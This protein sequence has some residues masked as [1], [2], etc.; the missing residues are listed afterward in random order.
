MTTLPVLP[1]GKLPMELL[2]R[3]LGRYDSLDDRV[4]VGPGVG[5]DAAVLDF[6]DVNLVVKSDPI[7]FPSDDSALYLVSVNANDL[8]CL[9]AVPRW[10][11]VTALL[12]EGATTSQMVESL[13]DDLTEACRQHDITLIGGHT[14]ITSG[15]E[16][17]L[18]IGTML[19][20]A[21]PD[22]L[23]MPGGARPGDRLI[24]TRPIA[25]EGTA[26]V[27]REFSDEL[28]MAFDGEFVER[29]AN[30]LV[31]PGI[32]IVDH[33]RALLKTGGVTA[34]HDPTEGGLATGLREIA[35]ASGCGAMVGRDLIPV[36]PET[37][38]ICAHLGVDPLGLLASGSLLAAVRPEHVAEVVEIEWP[39]GTHP[40]VLGKLTPA[41]RGFSM[42][43][44]G[45]AAPL[46]SFATDEF[47]RLLIER[48]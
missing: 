2:A 18:L 31:K 20:E 23:L 15:L 16:R 10:L 48:A 36:L 14:E 5:R 21:R 25:V 11:M 39:D 32:S 6:G 34:L 27:A 44:N 8:A 17:V 24:L 4:I 40:V 28:R 46:P 37:A 9:G 3:V 12:P 41:E 47:A 22:G 19:G 26:L 42:V 45:E 43:S 38:M 35:I 29:A 13:F 30:L 7:T 33:A 1:V